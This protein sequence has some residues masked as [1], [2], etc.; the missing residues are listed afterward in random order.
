MK[1]RVILKDESVVY[2]IQERTGIVLI[3]TLDVWN[4][5]ADSYFF[6][7]FESRQLELDKAKWRDKISSFF[8][9]A[10]RKRI[11]RIGQGDGT[12]CNFLF[13]NVYEFHDEPYLYP[14]A[15]L[16]YSN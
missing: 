14:F 4:F 13:F 15:N 12:G 2:Y 1:C 7:I 8:I 11:V 10:F 3:F 5:K 9:S 16:Q 6:F